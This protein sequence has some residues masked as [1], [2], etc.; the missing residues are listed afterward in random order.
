MLSF[1]PPPLKGVVTLLFLFLNTVFLNIPLYGVTLIKILLPLPAFKIFF[2]RI[3]IVIAESWIRTNDGIFRLIHKIKWDIQGLEG[4]SQREG[5]LVLSNHQSWADILV[6]Q[7]AF[8][9]RIPFLKFFLKKELFWVPILGL[10]WWA[11]DYPFMK[12]YSKKELEASPTKRLKDLETTHKMCARFQHTPISILNFAEGTRFTA[13]KKQQQSSP[14]KHLLIPK[15]GGI[16]HT[17]AAM[18]TLFHAVLDVTLVYPQGV[19]TFWNFICGRIKT[20][21]VRI[22]RLALPDELLHGNYI[23]DVFFR[24]KFKAWTRTI[25]IKKDALMDQYLTDLPPLVLH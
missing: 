4:L 22:Q 21:I 3:L 19:P 9:R 5:Y 10:A 18:G 13:E 20:V 1:L 16:A 8:N 12:R 15:A 24:E 2:T 14:Y 23:E 11:L 25:W 6:L 7:H 17:V